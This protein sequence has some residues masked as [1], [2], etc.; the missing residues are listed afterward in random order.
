MLRK[1]VSK[2]YRLGW[3]DCS[4]RRKK[5]MRRLVYEPWSTKMFTKIKITLNFNVILQN[6]LFW[7]VTRV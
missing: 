2:L 7:E 3:M 5:K 1:K 6:L 4:N